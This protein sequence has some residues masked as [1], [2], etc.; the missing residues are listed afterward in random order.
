MRLRVVTKWLPTVAHHD[1]DLDLDF[2]S[3][4]F[5]FATAENLELCSADAS[6]GTRHVAPDI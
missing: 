3:E 1:G 5:N 6:C 4:E 2:D